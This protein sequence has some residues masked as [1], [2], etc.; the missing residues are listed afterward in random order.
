LQRPSRLPAA[1]A[2]GSF[3][4][5][6]QLFT[7]TEPR[8]RVEQW[9]F[10]LE[11]RDGRWV[12]AGREGVG[13]IDGLVHLSLDP[14]GYRARG[15]TLRFD[16]FALEMRDGTL[17]SSPA[18]VGPTALVFVGEALVRFRPWPE[19]EREQ[20]RQF[21]GKPELVERFGYRSFLGAP[22]RRGAGCLG[23][24]EV[25]TKDARRFGP[26][27]QALMLAFADQAA[28]AIDSSLPRSPWW[29]LPSLGDSS[30]TFQTRHH[31]TLTFTVSSSEPEAISLF[32]RERRRQICLYPQQGHSAR[33]SEDDARSVDVVHHDLRVRFD[34]RTYL[35]EAEDTLRLRLLQPNATVRLRLDEGL[36]IHSVT[37]AEAGYHLFFR[38]RYQDSVMVSLGALAGR[39]GDVS[40]TVR[41]GGSLRPMPVEQETTQ[42][43][44]SGQVAPPAIEEDV[45]IEEVLV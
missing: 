42:A 27:E 30:V 33:Y 41:Y 34:P 16:D 32:D 40:L 45:M 5:S 8:G 20:L 13:L 1:D 19:T 6:A 3:K 39:T 22:L 37:S 28:V 26:E 11:G 14:H 9:L 35:L 17:F 38:V 29:L 10:T 18:S 24:L 2:R 15:L 4:V 25:V 36:H 21:G 44:G 23:T 43:P 12:L 7:L 31:R